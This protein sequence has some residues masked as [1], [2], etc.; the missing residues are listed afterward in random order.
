MRYIFLLSLFFGACKNS[1]VPDEILPPEKM[2][3]VLYDIIRA[4]EMVDFL[5]MS[6]STYRPFA[7]R[8][9]LYDTVFGLHGVQ[10]ETFQQSLRYYQGRP[11]LL[12]E[13]MEDM[14]AKITDTTNKPR[15]EV[16]P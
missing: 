13:I 8:T 16:M 3:N 6:D 9:A 1:S 7:K 12:K 5:R 10:K 15:P 4:D 14:H 11:D 2:Q